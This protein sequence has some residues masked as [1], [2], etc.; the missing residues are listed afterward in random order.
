M[1]RRGFPGAA[2]NAGYAM[3]A[4]QL[5]GL[6][7]NAPERGAHIRDVV[8]LNALPAGPKRLLE[9]L[10]FC[11]PPA[12]RGNFYLTTL[13]VRLLVMEFKRSQSGTRRHVLGG[14]RN[15]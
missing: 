3:A 11:L 6:L 5:S 1:D 9:N 2:T 7:P 8:L 12:A 10:V 14:F 15:P 4:S 13:L